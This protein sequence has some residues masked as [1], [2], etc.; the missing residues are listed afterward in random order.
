MHDSY[1][2]AWDLAELSSDVLVLD[3]QLLGEGVL[4]PWLSKYVE[5]LEK[6]G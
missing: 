3:V 2:V 6:L 5:Y 4:L 1:R